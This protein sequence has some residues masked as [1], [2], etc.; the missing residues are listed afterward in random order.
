[1]SSPLTAVR[2]YRRF[3]GAHWQLVGFG[4][5]TATLSGFGQTFYIGLFNAELRSVFA[6]SHGEFGLLYGAATLA[7][8]GLLTYVGG[9]YD[10]TDLRAYLTAA[11]VVLAAGCALMAGAQSLAVLFLAL[12]FLRH[13]GQGLMGHI[14]QTTMAHRFYAGRGKAVGVAS[15]GFSL[16]QAAFP[17]AAVAAL[18]VIDWRLTWR[19]AAGVVVAFFL[20]ILLGLLHLADDDGEDPPE[21][22]GREARDWTVRGAVTDTRFALIAPAAVAAPFVVTVV[23]FHQVPIAASK[24]WS[25]DLLAAGLSVYAVGH[26]I[27]LLGGGPMV[28]RFTAGLI[29]APSLLPMIISMVV[30]G[31]FEAPWAALCW[32]GLLGLSMGA[33]QT[34][35]TALLAELY[36][37]ANLGG[38]RA[39]LQALMVLSTAIGPPAV[40]WL[41]DEGVGPEGLGIGMAAGVAGAAGLAWLTVGPSARSR[42]RAKT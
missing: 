25:M 32:M 22:E 42:N 31:G 30:L 28:D 29:L 20:P 15:L 1:M 35:A 33:T 27:G 12:L 41:L 37:G 9:L 16:A 18:A 4:L 3:L 19:F 14:A 34:V 2:E 21:A 11:A 24:G 5:L 40:G 26:V 13:G 7:S 10:R 39:I 36:G 38:I 8:A 23:F 17:S 6:L